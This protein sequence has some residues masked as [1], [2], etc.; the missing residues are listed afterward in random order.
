MYYETMFTGLMLFGVLF[1]EPYES[2][3]REGDAAFRRFAN[4]SAITFFEQA[5]ARAPGN[6]EVLLRL[7]RVNNDQGRLLLRKDKIRSEQFYMRAA[8][9]AESLMVKY[10][11]RAESRF[12]I[13]LARGSL[14]PFR[15]V[16]DKIKIGKE[17]KAN[18]TEA[19]RIDSTLSTAYVVFAIF[20]REGAQLSWFERTIVR[21]VFGGD[22]EG[23]MEE[24]VRLLRKA[25][26]ID[27]GNSFAWYELHHTYRDMN[28]LDEASRAL[29]KVISFTP[30]NA[31][32]ALQ[33]TD[34]LRSFERLNQGNPSGR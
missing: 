6:F 15:G 2:L 1:G 26:T 22:M 10:P 7:V 21:V 30:D 19:L 23:T 24:S 27:P 29:E 20:E 34:A 14:I 13:A 32:E 4:E 31:R 5:Y 25:L 12:W 9:W 18:L 28:R 11:N 16:S 33:R 3:M 17:V 8:G